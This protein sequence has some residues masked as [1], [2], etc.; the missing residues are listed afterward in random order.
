M[1]QELARDQSEFN[2]KWLLLLPLLFL[3][4]CWGVS[5]LEFSN[6]ENIA[7]EAETGNEILDLKAG[8]EKAK[9]VD[10]DRSELKTKGDFLSNSEKSQIVEMTDYSSVGAV[11]RRYHVCMKKVRVLMK[12]N[13]QV[14]KLLKELHEK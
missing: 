4:T 14:M 1:Q 3:A 10:S 5:E 11:D 7:I 9:P 2:R 8:H 6:G 13:P 12:D